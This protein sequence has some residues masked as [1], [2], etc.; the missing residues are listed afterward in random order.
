MKLHPIVSW[1]QLRNEA[2]NVF[3]RHRGGKIRGGP[4]SGIVAIGSITLAGIAGWSQSLPTQPAQSSATQALQSAPAQAQNQVRKSPVAP[5]A[6]TWRADFEGK[7]FLIVRLTLNGD[8][9]TGSVE[10]PRSIELYDNGE[11][12]SVSSDHSSEVLQ[13]TKITGDGLLLIVKDE[14]TNE[15]DR[16]AMQLTSDTTANIKML[17]MSMPPGMP[18][19]KPWKLTK[20]ATSGIANPRQ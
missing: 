14:T 3:F 12:K 18:K 7:Q 20:S 11:L 17:A 2:K 19:P 10:H 9:M 8:Q 1:L 13:D 6:G 5:Y 16:F 15:L 4:R